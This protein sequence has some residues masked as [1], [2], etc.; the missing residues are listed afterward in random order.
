[1]TA[2]PDFRVISNIANNAFW[3]PTVTIVSES[4]NFGGW[5]QC[6]ISCLSLWCNGGYL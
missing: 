6:W 1:M 5:K 3:L 4:V 2:S